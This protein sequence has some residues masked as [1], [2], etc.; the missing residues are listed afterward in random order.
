MAYMTEGEKTRLAFN[1]AINFAIDIAGSDGLLFLTMW[2]EGDWKG[3]AEEFPEFDL[4]TTGQ[5]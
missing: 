5:C 4:N 2:R 1:S 3:I